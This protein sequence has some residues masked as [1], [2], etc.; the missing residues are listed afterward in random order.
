MATIYF[1]N[2]AEVVVTREE[3]PLERARAVFEQQTLAVLGYGVQGPGQAL[4]LRDNGFKVCIGQRKGS[5]SWDKAL[6][7]GWKEGETL[8]EPEA[9]CAQAEVILNL[10]SDAGQL[11]TWPKLLPYLQPGKTL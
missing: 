9:A 2:E 8:F 3:F 1:G 11:Q 5:A 7:D 10:L 6:A 4:N